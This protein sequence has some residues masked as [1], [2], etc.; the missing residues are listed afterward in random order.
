MDAIDA[1]SFD[2]NGFKEL[3]ACLKGATGS[4]KSYVKRDIG[5]TTLSLAVA[6]GKFTISGSVIINKIDT[7]T[8]VDGVV[9]HTHSFVFTGQ[10]TVS[11]A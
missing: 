7:E 6:A 4:F 5:A 2:S 8:P 1:T 11:G 10:V 9:D 3:I